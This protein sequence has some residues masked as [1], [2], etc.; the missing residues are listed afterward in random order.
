MWPVLIKEIIQGK[1]DQG[2][3][4]PWL[5]CVLG[6]TAGYTVLKCPR[7]VWWKTPVS[8]WVTTVKLEFREAWCSQKE[9]FLTTK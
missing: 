3:V 4:S 6:V 1:H 5:C 9:G 8:C 2:H 7:S